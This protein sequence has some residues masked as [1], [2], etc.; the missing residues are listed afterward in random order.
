LRKFLVY[1]GSWFVYAFLCSTLIFAIPF[2]TIHMQPVNA[3][4]FTDGLYTAGFSA[5]AIMIIVHHGIVFIWTRN[6]TWFLSTAYALSIILYF[7]LGIMM[8]NSL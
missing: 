3:R 1:N 5:N 4:G 6:W 2:F 7:P 8:D